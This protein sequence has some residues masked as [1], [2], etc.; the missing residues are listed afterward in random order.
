MNNNG[1]ANNN[2]PSNTNVGLR[3]NPV[4]SGNI[5][6]ISHRKALSGEII[7]PDKGI[8][9]YGCHDLREVAINHVI[10]GNKNG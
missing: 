5:V 2:T 10:M 8:S 1:N 9:D 7:L 6:I 4:F 3:P